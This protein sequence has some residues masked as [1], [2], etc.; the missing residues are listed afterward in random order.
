VCRAHRTHL[1][2]GAVTAF[3]TAAQ[4][5]ITPQQQTA[6]EAAV[7]AAAAAAVVA[8]RGTARD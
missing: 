4:A 8:D 1:N 6:A 7:A 5:A 3:C 2:R